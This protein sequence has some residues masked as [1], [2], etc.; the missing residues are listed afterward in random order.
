MNELVKIPQL[1]LQGTIKGDVLKQIIVTKIVDELRKVN[2]QNFKLDNQITQMI[3]QMVEDVCLEHKKSKI[4]KKQCVLDILKDYHN[5]TA[6]ELIQIGN[7][8]EYII[9]NKIIKQAKHSICTKVY[10]KVSK[11]L[12]TKKI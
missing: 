7:Q 8:I 11:V 6:Q 4:D 1:V 3:M 9:S 12:G 5:L 2:L 10:R